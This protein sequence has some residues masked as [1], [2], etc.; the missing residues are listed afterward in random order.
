[1][2]FLYQGA[3][4]ASLDTL[5]GV[6]TLFVCAGEPTSLNEASNT[7]KIGIRINHEMGVPE[8]RVPNGRKSVSPAFLDGAVETTGIATHWALCN[9]STLFAT[10]A[11]LDSQPLIALNS[12]S[13]AA[14]D[15]GIAEAE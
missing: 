6:D 5:S 9:D 2:A 15:I 1:M 3:L 4:D 12:F 14:F 8:D 10:G 13:L 11:L 7:L